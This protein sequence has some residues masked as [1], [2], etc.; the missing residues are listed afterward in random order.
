MGKLGRSP[1]PRKLGPGRHS[2]GAGLYLM[3]DEPKGDRP[4]TAR[5]TGRVYVDGKP[6]DIGLGALASKT[7]AEA[8]LALA[9]IKARIARGDPLR[10]SAPPPGPAEGTFKAF[11]DAW[12][13][14][15]EARLK[16]QTDVRQ[17]RR[18]MNIDLAPLHHLAVAE[19]TVDHVL[20]V[21][22]PL[23][24]RYATADRAQNRLEIA[25]D[26]A[27]V[28]GLRSGENPARWR[29]HLELVLPPRQSK[30]EQVHH[31]ALTIEEAPAFAAFLRSDPERPARVACL[32]WAML[33]AS[34]SSEARGARWDEVAGA[35]WT[36]PASRMKAGTAHAVPLSDRCLEILDEMRGRRG[37][38]EAT[39]PLVFAGRRGVMS[40]SSLQITRGDEWSGKTTTHG[41]RAVF[42]SWAAAT[43]QDRDLAELCLAHAIDG[44]VARAYQRHDLIEARRPILQAWADH[45]GTPPGEPASS[46]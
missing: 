1:D 22:R 12:L 34:R 42:R 16:N 5:W 37:D 11:V 33:T 9:E 29:G 35:V 2:D 27:R 6:R 4:Y 26:A 25:L 36:I 45:L 13:P 41:L 31:A 46:S 10:P 32:E 19:I 20:A 43:R 38:T 23:W 28:L 21:L 24:A 30:R 40:N 7:P 44:A 39:A 18:T 14:A 3:V 17:W 15:R 8:A